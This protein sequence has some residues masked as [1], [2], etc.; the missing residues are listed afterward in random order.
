MGGTVRNTKIRIILSYFDSKKLKSGVDFNRNGKIQKEIEKLIEVE[1]DTTLICLGDFNGRLTKLE[2][3][4]ITD[5]NGK[6][7]EDWTVNFDLH[8]LNITEKCTG[9]YTFHSKNGKSAIDH[10]LVNG[11]LLENYMGMHID[12]DRV[13]LNIS[14]HSLLRVWFKLDTN[15]ERTNWKGTNSKII[16]WVSKE[17]VSE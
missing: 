15:N 12:E 11:T 9:S 2:P 13:M 1:P 10:V 8:H 14:D 4:I 7:I 17:K 16:K 5:V 3:S 6:M